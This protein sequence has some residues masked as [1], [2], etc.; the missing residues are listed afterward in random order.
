MTLENDIYARR[1]TADQRRREA[2]AD[3]ELADAWIGL[4]SLLKGAWGREGVEALGGGKVQ[5][6]KA[7]RV[8]G[9]LLEVPDV[10]A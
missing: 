7:Y 8:L 1:H 10:A 5:I 3:Y 2:Q 9:H 6:E 4:D